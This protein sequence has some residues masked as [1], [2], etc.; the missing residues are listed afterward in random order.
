MKSANVELA[1]KIIAYAVIV[2][3]VA[4]LVSL[5]GTVKFTLDFVEGCFAYACLC[6]AI[7]TLFTKSRITN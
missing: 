3:I 4:Y 2:P 1:W 5:R 6:S 7:I